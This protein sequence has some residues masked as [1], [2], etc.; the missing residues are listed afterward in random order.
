MAWRHGRAGLDRAGVLERLSRGVRRRVSAR[1]APVA[2]G[3]ALDQGESVTRVAVLALALARVCWNEAGWDSPQD[4]LA[5]A[6]VVRS[7]SSS[8]EI[9][10]GALQRLAPHVATGRPRG[11]HQR[12]ST[13][14]RADGAR[15]ASW[16]GHLPWERVWRARW[17]RVLALSRAL[18]EGRVRG[19]CERAPIAWGGAMDRHLAARRRL[20]RVDCGQTR[21]EFWAR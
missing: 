8:G 12:L 17:L 14:L 19:R 21:N 5:I 10:L 6:E 3:G 18:V 11:A 13:E 9:T 1:P 20:T 7:T 2:S 16:P 15:P 4:C